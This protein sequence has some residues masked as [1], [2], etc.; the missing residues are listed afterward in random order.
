MSPP[1]LKSYIDVI[2]EAFEDMPVL[3]NADLWCEP[4]RALVADSTSI[5]VKVELVRG[6]DVFMNDGAYGNLFDA[7]HCKWPFPMKVHRLDS[8]PSESQK[9]FTLYGPTCDPIDVLD[10]KIHLPADL[11]EGDYIEFG[12][13]GAYGTTLAT[14]FNGFGDTQTVRVRESINPTLFGETYEDLP[15]YADNVIAFPKKQA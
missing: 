6:E 10:G 1:D 13:L 2:E 15:V 9:A 5:L 7:A 4:G 12:M 3:Y 11:Q 14:R 8:P